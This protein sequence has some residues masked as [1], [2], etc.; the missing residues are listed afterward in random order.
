MRYFTDE[1]PAE[2][3]R[4]ESVHPGFVPGTEVLRLTLEGPGAGFLPAPV[5]EGWNYFFI[6]RMGDSKVTF[7]YL[8]VKEE[9]R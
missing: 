3:T 7:S 1:P 2:V 8:R 5:L 6:G 4:T 9:D